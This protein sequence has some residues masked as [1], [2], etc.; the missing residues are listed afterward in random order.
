MEGGRKMIGV[1]VVLAAVVAVSLALEVCNVS[2]QGLLSCKPAVTQPNPQPPTHQCC[3]ALSGANLT[4]LCQYKNSFIL[5]S[6][7][8][9]PALA[10][11]LP[12]RCNITTSAEC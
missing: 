11:A 1:A 3:Q 4:C 12:A 8:I 2:E 6:L 9:N 7:G 5:P 10:L